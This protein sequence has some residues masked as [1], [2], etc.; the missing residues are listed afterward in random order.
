MLHPRHHGCSG[1]GAEP[2]VGI[3]GV[4]GRFLPFFPLAPVITAVS[5]TP[6]PSLSIL[7][8]LA[9]ESYATLRRARDGFLAIAYDDRSI[10]A[11]WVVE[12]GSATDG[13]ATRVLAEVQARRA[14]PRIHRVPSTRPKGLAL[15]AGLSLV[16]ADIVAV[17]DVDAV[18]HPQQPALAARAIVQGLADFVDAAELPEPAA[19]IF[20]R[21]QRAEAL[22]WFVSMRSMQW[23]FGAHL[24]TGGCSYY[25][26]QALAALGTFSETQAGDDTDASLKLA[27]AGLRIETVNLSSAGLSAESVGSAWRQR[28]RWTRAQLLAVAANRQHLRGGALGLAGCIAMSGILSLAV[29]PLGVMAV[30]GWRRARWS[31]AVILVAEAARVAAAARFA[32]EIDDAHGKPPW[33]LFYAWDLATVASYWLSLY[34][35]A[36]GS[37]DWHSARGAAHP[38]A[39]AWPPDCADA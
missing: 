30:A 35:L 21:I 29:A 6:L 36:T 37:T 38:G 26:R 3:G 11:V 7:V 17:Y 16:T 20:G 33:L 32:P 14:M 12:R 18:P 4:T 13:A 8:P 24:V 19:G 28:A 9:E 39:M 15:N 5:E 10:E 27:A 2:W 34:D 1:R 23:W 31:C 22:A 25:S